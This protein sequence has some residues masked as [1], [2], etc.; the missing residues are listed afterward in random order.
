MSVTLIEG[1]NKLDIGL[2]RKYVPPEPATLYG[3][4]L[5]TITGYPIAGAL[6]EV[7][8]AGLSGYTDASGNYEITDIPVGTYTIRAS[9][10]DY[11][12]LQMSMELVSGENSLGI[13]L[14]RLTATLSGIVT[15]AD[16][17]Y[18]LNGVLVE[19]VEAGLSSHTNSS[20][21]YEIANIPLGT[22]SIRF[23]HPDYETLVI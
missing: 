16:T 9:H 6:V 4:V 21:N 18:A 5:E 8:E 15:D 22:Y 13:A 7:V 10:P 12:T 19:V 20:G 1:L 14:K 3:Q 2:T 17:G 23:S 11:E